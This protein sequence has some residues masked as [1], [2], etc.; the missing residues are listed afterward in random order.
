[1]A[2]TNDLSRD[3]WLCVAVGTAAIFSYFVLGGTA[4]AI[5]L[6]EQC[7]LDARKASIDLASDPPSL[8]GKVISRLYQG[9]YN[10][11]LNQCL[12]LNEQTQELADNV[13]VTIV[14]LGNVTGK[15]VYAVYSENPQSP[16]KCELT[17][18]DQVKTICKSREEFDQFV[19]Q[20]MER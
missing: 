17:P 11:E 16:L 3:L 14:I 19:L 12:L 2:S 6:Q 10:K 7:Q 4:Q 9:H 5:D 8:P 20:Y 15:G 13:F 18:N 1:M